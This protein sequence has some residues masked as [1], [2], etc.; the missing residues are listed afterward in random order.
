MP[1]IF[2]NSFAKRKVLENE[3][4]GGICKSK[5]E[6]LSRIFEEVAPK[7]TTS[8]T[9]R[10]SAALRMIGKENQVEALMKGIL[11]D[12]QMLAADHTIKAANHAIEAAT[13]EQVRQL[14]EA[15]K[16]CPK[17]SRRGRSRPLMIITALGRQG[18]KTPSVVARNTFSGPLM[19]R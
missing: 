17:Q 12:V 19:V 6:T 14:E 1:E 3:V 5:A 13:Q 10:Y 8:R 18:I 2:Q 15:I 7:S 9:K 4:R 11:M 16:I